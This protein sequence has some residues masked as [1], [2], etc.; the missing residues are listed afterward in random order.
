VRVLLVLSGLLA[1]CAACGGSEGRGEALDDELGSVD[2]AVLGGSVVPEGRWNEV[3]AHS[4]TGVLIA[5]RWVLTAGHCTAGN[6]SVQLKHRSE[7]RS[8]VQ[9][10]AYV[11]WQTTLDVGLL[12]LGSDSAVTPARLAFGCG[13]DFVVDGAPLQIVGYGA[14]GPD[15]S[16]FNVNMRE[17]TTSIVDADCSGAGW[18]CFVPGK[19]LI[20]GHSGV[21]TCS[22]DSGGPAYVLSSVGPLLAGITSRGANPGATPLGGD[23]PCGTVP[24]LY[25]RTDGLV[26]WIESVI[27][28]QLP[29]P[30]C[31][32]GSGGAGGAGGVGGASG[33]G[34]AGGTGAGGM[35]GAGGTSTGGASG[36][37]GSGT[38]G[39]SGSG[40][41]SGSGS[42]VE[43]FSGTLQ[44]NQTAARGPF[45]V[46]A[47]SQLRVD[48][49]GS[50]DADLYVR[51]GSRPTL[52]SYDCR[53]YKN[54]SVESCSL[55]VPA[56]A[57]AVYID[58]RGY[59]TSS[60][61]LRVER[62]AATTPPTPPTT[63]SPP[64]PG[65]PSTFSASGSLTSKQQRQLSPIAV[66][67]GSALSVTMTGTGD[68]DLYVRFAGAPT[69]NSYDC[70]PYL[71]SASEQCRLTVPASAT[72]FYIMVHGYGASTYSIGASY[73]AP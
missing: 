38:G 34:G 48:L 1:W 3:S 65:T 63:P 25:V 73:M 33:A 14:D 57:T 20:A 51:F 19:E 9:T 68:P 16:Q 44:L 71:T 39:V 22:G 35:S 27:G 41:T 21:D 30:D 62:V 70:R 56:S 45:S 15:G 66:K 46:Q 4:C 26:D 47:G 18:S 40:G 32:A 8:V 17:A 60:Y 69:L 58:V 59:R 72:Q 29:E 13:S 53:P 24:G 36:T 42:L 54:N 5:K 49:S 64:T 28:E 52:T 10:R 6:G 67:P 50:G 55:R 37:G 7:T 11:S 2:Q 12:E 23:A 61:S 31:S 43:A